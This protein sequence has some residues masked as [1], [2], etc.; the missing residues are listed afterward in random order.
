MR[1]EYAMKWDDRDTRPGE[2]DPEF[3]F[4]GPG[5]SSAWPS[6]LLPK[7]CKPEEGDEESG[8]MALLPI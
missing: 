7:E 3:E 6:E 4:K 5:S 1:K 2:W 8:S